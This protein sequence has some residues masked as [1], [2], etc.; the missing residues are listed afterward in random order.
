MP[1]PEAIP[2]S[3][4]SITKTVSQENASVPLVA[5]IRTT[6]NIQVTGSVSHTTP[7]VNS[8]RNPKPIQSG[9][10]KVSLSTVPTISKASHN[11][12]RAIPTCSGIMF[13]EGSFSSSALPSVRV[14]HNVNEAFGHLYTEVQNSSRVPLADYSSVGALGSVED[15]VPID[16]SVSA[17]RPSVTIPALSRDSSLGLTATPLRVTNP[18]RSTPDIASHIPGSIEDSIRVGQLGFVSGSP[19]CC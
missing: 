15:H 14:S 19:F 18:S 3:S 2:S 13:Q 11:N 17:V 10:A 8:F 16:P 5:G 4:S 9:K 12:T 7:A 6:P 1:C